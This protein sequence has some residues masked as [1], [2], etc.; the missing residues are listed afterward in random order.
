MSLVV[1][2]D[3]DFGLDFGWNIWSPSCVY[4]N[5][6][7][8]RAKAS[9]YSSTGAHI[10]PSPLEKLLISN[11][12]SPINVCKK[13][14]CDLLTFAHMPIVL[15][16]IQCRLFAYLIHQK[17][18]AFVTNRITIQNAVFGC[19]KKIHKTNTFVCTSSNVM[20]ICY[21]WQMH[22]I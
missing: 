21:F 14:Q 10:S 18:S 3:S 5:T 8:S 2:F 6:C 15:I 19:R 16:Y 11:T 7:Q 12:Y 22:F 1:D 4:Y 20:K 13:K 9:F 17:L